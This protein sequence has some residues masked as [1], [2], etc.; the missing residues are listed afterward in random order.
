MAWTTLLSIWL[1]FGVISSI[2]HIVDEW[3]H[4]KIWESTRTQIIFDTLIMV[5]LCLFFGPI[6]IVVKIWE[7]WFDPS[8]I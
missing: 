8:N 1:V 6:G 7:K 2:W 5:T 4:H 3:W